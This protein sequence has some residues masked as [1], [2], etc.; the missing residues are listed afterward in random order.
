MNISGPQYSSATVGL[1]QPNKIKDQQFKLVYIYPMLC[2]SSLAKYKDMLRTFL[3]VSVLKEIYTSNSISFFNMG[4][5]ISPLVD[6]QGNV[7]DIDDHVISNVGNSRSFGD[8]PLKTKHDIQQSI[9]YDIQEKINERSSYIK[10]L[11]QIDPQL[12][13]FNPYVQMITMNNFINIPVIVGTKCFDVDKIVM[14][15][16]LTVA[17]S[18]KQLTMTSYPDIQKIFRIIKNTNSNDLNSILNHLINIPVKDKTLREKILGFFST[19]TVRGNSSKLQRLRQN[20]NRIPS[21]VQKNIELK[22]TNSAGPKSRL[23]SND[24][25][26]ILNS[27]RNQL[28][29]IVDVSKNTVNQ[30]E[31]FFKLCMDPQ[32]MASQFGYDSSRGQLKDTFARINPQINSVFES[33]K[34][35]FADSIWPLYI[36]PVLKSFLYTIVPRDSGVNVSDIIIALQN[37]D[38]SKNIKGVFGPIL[39]YIT[40]DFKKAVNNTIENQG[41]DKA[42]ITLNN[43]KSL[44]VNHFSESSKKIEDI[45]DKF[46]RVEL[47]GP[48]Y[49][50]AEHIAYEKTFEKIVS[51]L[52]PQMHVIESAFKQILPS[53]L[54]DDLL[55]KKT[56]AVINDGLN[57]VITYFNT[58]DSYPKS[59]AFFFHE[60]L[61]SV[62]KSN[63]DSYIG[64]SKQ[65]IIFYIRKHILYIIQYILC[66]YVNETKIAVETT[67]HD[68]IDS[69]NYSLV[70]PL[71]TIMLLANAYAAKSYRNL[72]NTS[73]VNNSSNDPR[74]S[75]NTQDMN[76]VRDLS[77]NYVKAIIKFMHK[78][79][80]VPN[81]FVIDEARQDVY[82]KLMYQ[83]NVNKIKL[84]TIDTYSKNI[85]STYSSN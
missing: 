53:S 85:L 38:P 47:T 45:Q 69:N 27:T 60:R 3:S 22:R 75:A 29:E 63:I 84:N 17:V 32:L 71:E 58:F 10:K 20:I 72:Y 21:T 31:V 68:V 50:I 62:D 7:I 61:N 80:D 5:N 43:L 76:L 36:V 59:T 37:G 40:N 82:Y 48:D 26:A 79:L 35:L 24:P 49:D 78:Q 81:L 77:Q 16:V 44:C 73:V 18:D 25:R 64:S 23:N 1:R 74:N 8:N 41:P 6:N 4:S 46:D 42:D 70:L 19:G 28:P 66:K 83:S 56:A 39:N 2:D 57:S 9:K 34:V 11:T 55:I 14:L 30:A 13:N 65:Q 54:I 52:V 15:M 51:E 33:A 67:K 12:K